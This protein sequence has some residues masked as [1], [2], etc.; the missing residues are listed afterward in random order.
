M[1]ASASDLL[2]SLVYLARWSTLPNWTPQWPAAPTPGDV[3]LDMHNGVMHWP[4]FAADA[5]RIRGAHGVGWWSGEDFDEFCANFGGPRLHITSLLQAT[6]M[7][8]VVSLHIQLLRSLGWTWQSMALN[9][10]NDEKLNLDNFSIRVLQPGEL[11]EGASQMDFLLAITWRHA[12][13]HPRIG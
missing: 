5:K 9:M 11:C 13:L 12:K 4:A 6:C 3:V 1:R 8:H 10:L 7:D 2:L